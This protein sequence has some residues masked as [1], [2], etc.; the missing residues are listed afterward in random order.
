MNLNQIADFQPM[1]RKMHLQLGDQLGLAIVRGD[2]EEDK[3]LPSEAKLC[4]TLGVSRTSMR[5]AI[6]GLV[7]KGMLESKSKVGTRVRRAENW[8]HLDVDVLRWQLAVADTETY[9]R[10]M[11]QLRYATE[12]A[13]AAIAAQY[14]GLEDHS[15][16]TEAF[17]AMKMAGKDLGQ[18]VEADLRFHRAIYLAT[19][20]EFFWPIA[21]LF[22][23][24]LKE[25]FKI[26]ASGTHRP[27]AVAEHRALMDAIVA[28][29]PEVARE[30]SLRMLSNAKDDVL[31][32]RCGAAPEMKSE[33]I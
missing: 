24:A 12:P 33:T 31:S 7:A 16:I 8:N 4:E 20:N 29:K 10:K 3:L 11:F 18:W 26:T 25:M 30:L 21:Q 15:R 1:V 17:E 5:E 23:I 22:N 13:A 6:R 14:A 9:L 2:F 19:H 27:R 32:I 28:G